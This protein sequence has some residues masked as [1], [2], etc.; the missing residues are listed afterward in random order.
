M[1]FLTESP[2]FYNVDEDEKIFVLIAVNNLD[3]IN[4]TESMNTKNRVEW[5][6]AIEDELKINTGK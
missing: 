2:S 6:K 4:Y 5:Q 1:L 3:P